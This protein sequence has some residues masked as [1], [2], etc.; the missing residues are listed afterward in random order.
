MKKVT[1]PWISESEVYMY[2]WQKTVVYECYPKSFLDTRGQGTGTIEGIRQKL[3]YLSSLGTGAIWITPV[4][5]SPMVDNGYD[6]ADYCAI[7]PLFGTMEDMDRLISDAR[8]RGIRIVMDLV[9]N[10]TSDQHPWFL[11]SR[12]NKENPRSNWYIWR[13]AKE[14]GSAPANWRGIFGGSAW[15]WCEERGQYYLHTF[16]KEQPDLN[17]EEPEVRQALY[18]CAKFWIDKGIGGFR[19][20]A[21]TYI[22]KPAVFLDGLPDAEDGLVS[23]HNMTANTPGILDFLHEFRDHTVKGTDLFTVGEAN[24]VSAEELPEWVGENGVFDMLFEFS[25]VNLE[26]KKN[27]IWTR[28]DSWTIS[29]LKEALR[30]SQENTRDAWYPIFFE[31]HDKPRCV[32]HSFS[33]KADRTAAAKVIGMI[34]YTMRGT[35]FLYQGQE[36]GLNRVCWDNIEMYNDISSIGQYDLALKEGKSQAEAL[37]AV[38]KFSRD[39]A[40]VPMPWNREKNAGFTSSVPWLNVHENAEYLCAEQQQAN[41]DSVLSWYRSLAELRRSHSALIDGSYEEALAEDEDI[42]GYLRENEEERILVLANLSE[43]EKIYEFDEKGYMILLGSYREHTSGKLHPLEAIL[44]CHK[45]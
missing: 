44:L 23:I 17:W 29:E 26:F 43:K 24:G 12:K 36:L 37:A 25:H 9:F 16:A 7:D 34:L 19:I 31:N 45:K 10:H 39:N 11:E 32:D 42:L 6:I 22:K 18:Q 35:P 40:R 14:D 13:D 2:W 38:R 1:Y 27:E 3:D 15:T 21:I 30:N 20:D 33:E 41:P 28:P 8:D 4:Y 5:V